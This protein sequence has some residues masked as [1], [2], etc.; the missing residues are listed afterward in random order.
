MVKL[1]PVIVTIR[2]SAFVAL[3]AQGFEVV[4]MV[5]FWLSFASSN[6]AVVAVGCRSSTQIALDSGDGRVISIQEL[7]FQPW[8]PFDVPAYHTCY[9]LDALN[10]SQTAASIAASITDISKVMPF[11]ASHCST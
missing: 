1:T 3:S 6:E 4:V 11:D 8:K 10:S 7:F 2:V 5:K 9:L